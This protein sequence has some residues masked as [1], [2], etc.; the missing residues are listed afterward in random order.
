MPE[1]GRRAALDGCPGLVREFVDRLMEIDSSG[2][3]APWIHLIS[4]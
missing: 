3:W 4:I 2:L 1:I